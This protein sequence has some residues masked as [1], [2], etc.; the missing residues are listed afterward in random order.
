MSKLLEKIHSPADLRNLSEN[1][2]S[3]LCEEIRNTI[4]DTVSSN[5]GHLASNLGVVELALSLHLVFHLPD[6]S[7]VWD[8][9]HQSYPHK[10]LT[11]RYDQFATT[12]TQGGL[13]GFPS[14]EES[15]YDILTS[16]HASTSV[17]AAL[18]IAEA[19]FV[20][21]KDD[22][23]VAVIG[24]GALTGGLA[25]EGMNNAGRA[26][27]NLIVVLNDNT[28]SISKNVGSVARHLTYIRTRPS[29][30]R[31]K[32]NLENAV[33]KIPLLGKYLVRILK[34]FKVAV[35]KFFY[36]STLFEDM[37][38]TYYG[39]FDGH[40]IKDLTRILESVKLVKKPVLVHVV[41]NKGKGYKYAE[42]S[43]SE[44][45]GISGFDVLTGERSSSSKSFSDIFGK[46]LCDL[47]AKNDKICAIT[48]AMQD[49]TGLSMFREQYK[50]R[51]FDVGI[52]EE[53]AVTFAG[54]MAARGALPVFAVYSTFLQR[55]YDQM[56]HDV[57]L[58]NTK[59][60]LAIDRAGIVGED[61]KTHQGLFD[62]A[63]LQ[64]IPNVTL[65]SPSYF[66]ELEAQLTYLVEEGEKLCAIRYP[67]GIE[68]FKPK[69]FIPTADS[70]Q[71]YGEPD[72]EFAIVTYGRLF[73]FA[74][75][76]YHSLKQKGIAL[77]IVKLNRIIPIDKQAVK[78]AAK[79]RTVFF[80]EEAILQGGIGEHFSYLLQKEAFIGKYRIKAIEDPFVEHAP[81]FYALEAL[82]LSA[83]SIEETIFQE[84][85]EMK[86]G[87]KIEKEA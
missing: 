14:R 57:A 35:K 83:S 12:R 50:N 15:A 76:A 68:L 73:S 7:I 31:I 84:Y 21:G 18:G 39:P 66:N 74:A 52:A 20:Q 56:I 41:T 28:M 48:A 6:D 16:G 2:L 37:G 38:F 27:R 11:G 62:T 75:T 55:A 23:S 65:Y 61:G 17:S 72:A 71:V 42:K 82:G 79:C 10:L 85:K 19:N 13:S 64:T 30:I 5:G 87:N 53:H 45:H 24:D 36:K 51:F 9:G 33:M 49:G 47:A 26:K 46:V 22:F 54:G 63:Y 69:D 3:Q 8:V 60:I 4:I 77:K 80:Y 70:Y 86:V 67:R 44:Y 81:M 58:Q 32:K 40:S 43:P 1:E 59:M 25:Y 78:E 34:G 29:Y